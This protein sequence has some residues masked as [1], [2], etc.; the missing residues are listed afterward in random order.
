MSPSIWLSG[1]IPSYSMKRGDHQN[2]TTAQHHRSP[3]FEHSPQPSFVW[4][5]QQFF[6]TFHLVIYGCIMWWNMVGISLCL[7]IKSNLSLSIMH[8][9]VWAVCGLVFML[10]PGDGHTSLWPR[11]SNPHCTYFLYTLY[12]RYSS[13]ETWGS[14]TVRGWNNHEDSSLSLVGPCDRGVAARLG[15]GEQSAGVQVRRQ[16]VLCHDC[17]LQHSGG[18][19]VPGP[20]DIVQ[21]INK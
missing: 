1:A 21:V 18:G 3:P 6:Q 12:T 11:L 7:Q 14:C 19:S 4:S 5:Y 8:V 16:E 20:G 2:Q 9:P 13:Q 10:L 15:R 17:K